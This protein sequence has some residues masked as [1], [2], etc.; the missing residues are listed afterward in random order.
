MLAEDSRLLVPDR[1]RVAGEKI[2]AQLV[3]GEAWAGQLPLRRQGGD[4]VLVDLVVTPV[5]GPT[6]A[7]VA[8]VGVD[9]AVDGSLTA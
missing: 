9:R 8:I 7:V 5:K 4:E 3:A 1:T 2:Q 6:G